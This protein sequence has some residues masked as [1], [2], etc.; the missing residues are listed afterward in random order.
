MHEYFRRDAYPVSD[1]YRIRIRLGYASDTYPG[2]TQNIG[3]V[4][5]QIRVS[6]MLDTACEGPNVV[7]DVAASTY[8]VPPHRS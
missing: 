4:F 1:M 3:Y 6:D 7:R 8:S 2:R 5:T